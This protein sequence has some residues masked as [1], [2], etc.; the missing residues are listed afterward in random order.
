MT[1]LSGG[2][3][4]FNMNHVAMMAVFPHDWKVLGLIPQ[5]FFGDLAIINDV[6][7]D[8]KLLIEG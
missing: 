3:Y 2:K 5:S 1:Y 7:G 6:L 4:F 8:S